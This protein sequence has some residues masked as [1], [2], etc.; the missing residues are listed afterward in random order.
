[1]ET[2]AVQ[3]M[4]GMHTSMGSAWRE[5]CLANKQ[6]HAFHYIRAASVD[7][8]IDRNVSNMQSVYIMLR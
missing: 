4:S 5:G 7:V 8:T 3:V 1:M 6:Q 2:C